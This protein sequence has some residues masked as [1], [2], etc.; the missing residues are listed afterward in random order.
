MIH[1]ADFDK[2][3]S[4]DVRYPFIGRV[5]RKSG[6]SWV[7]VTCSIFDCVKTA[8]STGDESYTVGSAFSGYVNLT[9]SRLDSNDEDCGFYKGQELRIDIGVC[10][11]SSTIHYITWGYYTINEIEVSTHRYTFKAVG[12]ITS[13][14]GVTNFTVPSTVTIANV[15][16]N[17]ASDTGL[18]FTT[19][20]LTLSTSS[21]TTSLAGMTCKEVLSVVA[22]IVGAYA[23]ETNDGNVVLFNY[24]TSTYTTI[25]GKAMNQQPKF[26]DSDI[27]LD[28]IKVVVKEGTEESAE[29]SYSTTTAPVL[30]VSNQYMASQAMFN[31]YV[32]NLGMPSTQKLGSGFTFRPAQI[33]LVLGDPRLEATDVVRI[34]ADGT[35]YYTVPCMSV[36]HKLTGGITTDINAPELGEDQTTATETQGPV[37]QI[38]SRI[39][40]ELLTAKDIVA[41]SITV[42]ELT[43]KSGKLENAYINKGLIEDGSIESA[44][45]ADATIT[46]AKIADGTIEDAKINNL[47]AS[48][49]TSGTLD[50]IRIGASS[51]DA[52][53]IASNAITSDKI[54]ANAVTSEKIA[55]HTITASHIASN[56]ITAN[57]IASNTI[58]ADK[59][60]SVENWVDKLMVQ[61]GLISH[62]G[63]I[64]ELDAIQV[65]ATNIKAGTLDVE[66]LIYT[67]STTGE[68]YLVH[69]DS[70]GTASYQK[71][72]GNIVQDLTITADK[73]VAGAVTADKITTENI[74]GSGGWINLRNGTF[75]YQNAELSSGISWD[76]STLSIKADVVTIGGVSGAT[77][78][79][80]AKK[81]DQTALDT[82]NQ[83]VATLQNIVDN[84]IET[85]FYN[86]VPTL[87]NLPASEWTTTELKNR[88]IGD[89]Y[90]D[91]QTGYA[92]RFVVN[93]STYSWTQLA[94]SATAEALA[95][96]KAKKRV[97]VSTPSVPYDVGDLWVNTSGD[98]KVCTTAKT[99]AE[100]Y[101]ADDWV[102]SSNYTDDT[103]ANLAK[104]SAENAQTTANEATTKANNAQADAT[105]A[106]SD[107]ASAQTTASSA[108]STAT[109]AQTKAN[110]A[111]TTAEG[112]QSTAE[113]AQT[114]A[115]AVGTDLANN[116]T[117]TSDLADVATSGSYE[118][119]SAKPTIP[120]KTS[121]LTN[122]SDFIDTSYH[123]DTKYDASN[124][125]GYTDDTFAAEA[126]G[127]AQ[128][129]Q[130]S[131]D[132]AQ[133]I[134]K[135]ATTKAD[136]AQ[137]TADN[138]MSELSN[139][140]SA[141]D[142][143]NLSTE[144]N[145]QASAIA[146]QGETIEDV[147][148]YMTF[149]SDGLY[150]GK[151]SDAVK[152]RMSSDAFS[153][154][155]GE[156]GS[157]SEL[158]KFTQN[159]LEV[160]NVETDNEV[161][162]FDDWAIRKGEYISGKG[163]NLND[164]WIGG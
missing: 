30:L 136:N 34:T 2:I 10:E 153:I 109:S 50:A 21:I 12:R 125:N 157:E 3:M 95:L 104:Q 150:V 77:T 40:Y 29:V 9:T 144:V 38:L 88:H 151:S 118:D 120:S 51:I 90:Y 164:M 147:R 116:Y 100:S 115:D 18:T 6:N 134:A 41:N 35:N 149:N 48:K 11:T 36:S 44:K 108:Q 145:K 92:Y 23:T 24:D 84:T 113:S 53:K 102:K 117:K 83:N 93:G 58:T 76:G 143:V 33:S 20:G 112:A 7:Q 110:E 161:G 91:N 49:I 66:R 65:N 128:T 13:V 60:T 32:S 152:T 28:G 45:I 67:D 68:K 140:A 55:A 155:T 111:Q 156:I 16:R 94:D 26:G 148:A 79:E 130:T 105:Q 43:T 86:G 138:A 22:S 103:V 52:N 54:D 47:D 27:T 141:S 98:T 96:S 107:A 15:L 72:D 101:S 124:P 114:K 5:M 160:R 14:L 126:A 87:S 70:S 81:A 31:A 63:T 135:N 62:T 85:W 142:V 42:T 74:V 1:N 69:F 131:A 17:L 133:N 146:S 97:F 78:D 73:L 121:E 80:V 158:A 61:T 127:Q 82:T 163:Y 99:S 129:A 119:L 39:S 122:D 71:L 159:A 106:L 4:A 139:K 37:Q 154:V 19:T 75:D 137:E 25:T 64:Y 46:N 56:T 123:D 8:G 132:E 89:L 59:I 162:F 57:E